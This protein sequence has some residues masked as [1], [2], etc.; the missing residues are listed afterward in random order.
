M[1]DNGLLGKEALSCTCFPK[2]LYCSP[3]TC[4]EAKGYRS[5]P[6]AASRELAAGHMTARRPRKA[7]AYKA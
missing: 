2:V 6:A 4:V 3:F 1:R 5:V 7:L